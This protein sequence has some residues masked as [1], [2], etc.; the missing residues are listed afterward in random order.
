LEST[1]HHTAEDTRREAHLAV[2]IASA[3]GCGVH[4]L[5]Y[6]SPVDWLGVNEEGTVT[7]VIEG[8]CRTDSVRAFQTIW[9]EVAKVRALERMAAAFNVHAG[10]CGLFVAEWAGDVSTTRIFRLRAILAC[11]V[12]T[13]RRQDRA[14]ERPDPVYDVPIKLGDP[15]IPF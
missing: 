11:P 5:P 7:H 3:L 15:I 13:R 2:H 14:G 9:V 6:L 4:P 8:K 1:V 10:S 12:V